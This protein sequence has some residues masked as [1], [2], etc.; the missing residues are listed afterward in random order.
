MQGWVFSSTL[1]LYWGYMVMQLIKE[2]TIKDIRDYELKNDVD[3][4]SLL[5]AGELFVIQDLI[6]I[7]NKCSEDEASEILDK[8]LTEMGLTNLVKE[9]LSEIIGRDLEDGD[10]AVDKNEYKNFSEI[11]DD[12]YTQMQAVDTNL[13]IS[14][15]ESMTPKKMYRYA[16]G[17]QKRFI[18]KR[19]LEMQDQY[20]YIAMFMSALTGNLKQCPKLNMDGSVHKETLEEKIKRLLGGDN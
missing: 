6:Q 13:S 1:Y 9:I 4:L 16:D 15:F 8:A 11:L 20:N 10:P 18:V 12:F 5:E 19:N 17:L 2:I 14:E 7:G 3:T